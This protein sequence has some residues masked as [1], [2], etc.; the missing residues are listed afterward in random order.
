MPSEAKEIESGPVRYRRRCAESADFFAFLAVLALDTVGVGGVLVS[1]AFGF[2]GGAIIIAVAALATYAALAR[3]LNFEN[4]QASR[5]GLVVSQSPLPWLGGAMLEASEV[6][7]V[8]TLEKPLRWSFGNLTRFSIVADTAVGPVSVFQI[9]DVDD[10]AATEMA[11]RI[12]TALR[13][14]E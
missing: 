1:G 11:R 2:V 7:A 9:D 8:R 14:N 12:E 3:V 10:G 4:L 5:D 13:S 6:L